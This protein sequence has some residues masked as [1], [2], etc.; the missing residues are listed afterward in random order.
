LCI[1]LV[2]RVKVPF[3]RNMLVPTSIIAGILGFIIIN[4]GLIT[5]TDSEMYIEMV[6]YLFTIMFISLTL[7]SSNDSSKS[8]KSTGKN[9]TLGSIGIG[10]VW[11]LLFSLTPLIGALVLKVVGGAFGMNPIYGLLI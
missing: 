10:V 2:I 11:S 7:T 9:I 4:T 1:G 8:K 6:N 3:I 5:S